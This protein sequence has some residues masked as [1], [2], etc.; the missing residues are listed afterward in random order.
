V[1]LA[2]PGS[3]S[4]SGRPPRRQVRL[5][6]L[7]IDAVRF[8]EAL[9][10]IEDL[11]TSRAGGAVYTPNVDHVVT[12]D[13]DEGFRQA[14]ADASLSLVDGQPLVWSARLL[15]TP[16]PDKISGSD[17][18]WPLMERAARGGW[19]VYL[20]GG[21]P[22]VAELA[23]ARLARELG[24]AIVGTDASLIRLEASAAE[25]D[26]IVARVQAVRPDLILV[27]L[28]APK[29][30]RWIHLVRGRLQPAVLIGV[31]ASLDFI[32]GTIRRAPRW[33]SRLSLEWLYRLVR[34]PRRLAYRYL[35]KDPRFL[36]ILL[37][38]ALAPLGERLRIR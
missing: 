19:R 11:V 26:S 30:E 29:Q 9:S 25:V 8:E 16:L 3:P 13:D 18:V 22:G 31:G 37:R 7:W 28:G 32:A 33:M 17:L 23:A 12:A 24:V 14:Y 27:A 38:T 21:D 20:L 10:A 35:W 6:H 15:G 2:W 5:G 1:P 36:A 4:A 34:E